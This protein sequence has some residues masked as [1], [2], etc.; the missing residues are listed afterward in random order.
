MLQL[1]GDQIG[2]GLSELAEME[3]LEQISVIEMRADTRLDQLGV[4]PFLT[5][6]SL[7]GEGLISNPLEG[8]EHCHALE[9]VYFNDCPSEQA[10]KSLSDCPNLNRV[11]IY[12]DKNMKEEC[13][14]ELVN[15]KGLKHFSGFGPTPVGPRA[16]KYIA[17]ISS[18]ESLTLNP[19]A[20]TDDELQVLAKLC[21][22]R[23]LYIRGPNVTD[24]GIDKLRSVFPSLYCNG[25]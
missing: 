23:F 14:E 25:P 3:S 2:P 8:I 11:S 6:L 17:G 21:R 7:Y 18:L 19:T 10:L 15:I 12:F 1:R 20:V 13:L 4:L 9:F 16:L 5:E 22:L 24:S